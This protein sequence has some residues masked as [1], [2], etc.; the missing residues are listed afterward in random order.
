MSNIR[1][2]PVPTLTRANSSSF[3]RSG[4]GGNKKRR[5]RGQTFQDT[6]RK[7]QKAKLKKQKTSQMNKFLHKTN[8]SF[9]KNGL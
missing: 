7:F 6:L 1:I 5:H 4:S 3:G 2:N 8:D 9:P